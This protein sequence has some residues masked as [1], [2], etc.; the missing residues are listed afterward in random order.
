MV[1]IG[2]AKSR[3][4]DKCIELFCNPEIFKAIVEDEKLYY[5]DSTLEIIIIRG[6]DL[7]YAAKNDYIDIA[8]GSELL[9]TEDVLK[10]MIHICPIKIYNCRLSLIA[11]KNTSLD[12]IR[13]IGTRYPKITI[14]KLAKLNLN[15]EL[16]HLSG[17]MEPWLLN[18]SC[19]AIIDIINTG[20]TL[21]MYGLREV[22]ELGSVN[23]GIWLNKY[24]KDALPIVE[25]LERQIKLININSYEEI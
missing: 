11:K 5:R 13:I 21:E 20:K 17:C 10:K 23:H 4:L 3:G 22:M 16:I 9:L 2:I 12:K 24:R 8:I 6:T 15:P 18:N 14:R 19:D 7:A 25:K 1:R